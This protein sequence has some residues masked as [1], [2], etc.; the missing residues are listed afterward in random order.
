MPPFKISFLKVALFLHYKNP[1]H[2]TLII[3]N[4]IHRFA[5]RSYLYLWIYAFPGYIYSKIISTNPVQVSK[6]KNIL[7]IR[8]MM[9]QSTYVGTVEGHW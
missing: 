4:C 5:L 8:D 2:L 1:T 6:H 3:E 7:L 9:D